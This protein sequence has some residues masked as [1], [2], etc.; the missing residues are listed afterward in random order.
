MMHCLCTYGLHNDAAQV[1]TSESLKVFPNITAN[2]LPLLQP[3]AAALGLPVRC[4]G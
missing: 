4:V 2:L 1:V 3:N